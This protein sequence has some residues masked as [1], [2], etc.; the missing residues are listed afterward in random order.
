MIGPVAALHDTLGW[1]ERRPLNGAVVAVTR[2]RAQASGLAA[3][4]SGLGAEVIEAPAIR[5]EPRPLEGELLA[6]VSRI[7][8]YALVCLTSP[9]GVRLLFDALAEVGQ[10]ARALAGA[11]VAAIGPGTAAELERHGIRADVVPERFVAEGLVE[12]LAG[13]PVEGRAVLI[14]RAAEARSLLPDALRE[15]GA[16]VDDVALYDTRAERIDDGSR[17]RL[18]RATHVTFTSS[19][20]VRF[21]LDAGGE[22]PAGAR[23]VSIG[24]VTS[25]TARELGL[26]VDVEASRHDIDGLVDALV[27]DARESPAVIVTLLTDYGRDDD[28]VGVCHG[29]MR[30]IEPDL[31]IIDITHGINRYAVREGAL[32]LR[33]TLPFMP[34]GVHMAVVDPQVGTERRAVALRTG[35]GRTLVGPD[36]GLLSL[37][38]ERCGGVELAVDVTRSQHRLEPVSAT[39]HGRDIFAPVAA[40]LAA[41]AQLADAGDPLDPEALATVEL[42]QPRNEDGALVAHALVID[43]FG[44]VGLNVEPRAAGGQRPHA[45]RHASSSRPAASATSPSTRRPSPTSPSASCSSTRTPIARSPSRSTAATPPRRSACGRTQ[46][47]GCGR[48]DRNA[49]RPPA[50]DRLDERAR[51]GARPRRRSAR[52]ARDGRRAERGPRAA[53][54]GL[55]RA[56]ALGRADVAAS[57][58]ELSPT[59]PLAAAVAICDALPARCEIKWPNDIWLERRK[60]AGILVEGRPQEGWAVLGIGLNVDDRVVSAGARGDRHVAEDG[61]RRA[62]RRGRHRRPARLARRVARGAVRGGVRCVERARRPARRAGALGGRRGDRRRHRRERSARG[63]D[64]RRPGH[65]RRGRGP[66]VLSSSPARA[67]FLPR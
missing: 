33:N 37:A 5:I 2:A 30:S 24:P 1:L 27:A 7:R 36:N 64:G 12:E 38:W 59:L 16:D 42:P 62:G 34:V 60:L 55:D 13:V 10:D 11:T 9:N 48:D 3:R 66:P 47:C 31:R 4:L 6:A 19:S 49:A 35:D 25:A 45:R 40:H 65:A 18:A 29:V 15:R 50:A 14:A 63:R 54:K 17:E 39:F 41:G 67:G 46:R 53:G 51:Q 57:R 22:L 26:R 20:T 56:A 61:G 21:F 8:E 23:L 32:V 43:R 58:V 52:H 28:F 44:N